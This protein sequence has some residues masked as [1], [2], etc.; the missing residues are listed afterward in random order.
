M[1]DITIINT[2]LILLQE[3]NTCYSGSLCYIGIYFQLLS[4][5]PAASN[6]PFMDS[7]YKFTKYF[8]LLRK[9]V[10]HFSMYSEMFNYGSV[11]LNSAVLYFLCNCNYNTYA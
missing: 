6:L 10:E 11:I 4:I 9:R 5:V 2:Y 8:T 7:K 3:V 1:N